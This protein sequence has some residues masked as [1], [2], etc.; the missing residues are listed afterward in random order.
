[1][2]FE[3]SA[4]TVGARTP[5]PS[6]VKELTA[7]GRCFAVAGLYAGDPPQPLPSLVALHELLGIDEETESLLLGDGPDED[8][9]V[10]LSGWR[11]KKDP[12][13]AEEVQATFVD[14]NR[15]RLARRYAKLHNGLVGGTH[16][17]YKWTS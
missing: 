7:T 9:G 3:I 10:V 6:V 5:P 15:A 11:Y 1:M 13:D 17:C 16:C 12:N 2:A 4:S 8:Y 14:K